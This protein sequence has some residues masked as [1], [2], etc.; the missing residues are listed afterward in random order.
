MN[1]YQKM[2]LRTQAKVLNE[3]YS[4][5]LEDLLKRIDELEKEVKELKEEKK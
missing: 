1:D 2:F 5:L 4:S 3:S